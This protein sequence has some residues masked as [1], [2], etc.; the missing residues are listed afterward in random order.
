MPSM[1]RLLQTPSVERAVSD[2]CEYG[3]MAANDSG[4]LV[5]AKKPTRW[6]SNSKWM[7]SRLNRRCRGM[8]RHQHLLAGRS[9]KAQEYPIDL[10]V[11]IV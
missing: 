6:A 3:L 1:T 8:H 4:D 10:I 2:Q 7:L 11:E 5:Q 9:K